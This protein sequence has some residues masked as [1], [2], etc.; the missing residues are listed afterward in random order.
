[1]IEALGIT[2]APL[3]T[4]PLQAP[5]DFAPWEPWPPAVAEELFM[6]RFRQLTHDP[7]SGLVALTTAFPA[8][9]PQADEPARF[10]G[11]DRHVAQS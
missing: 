11:I 7:S 2:I 9:A 1:M 4:D 8:A 3:I 6:Q 5:C 10:Q